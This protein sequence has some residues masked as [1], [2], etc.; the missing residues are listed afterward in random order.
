MDILKT[1][2][3]TETSPVVP[4]S[5]PIARGH[6][7]IIK[8]ARLEIEGKLILP[9]SARTA[10]NEGFIMAK[11]S[12]CKGDFPIGIRV[13]FNNMTNQVIIHDEEMYL[14]AHE[15]DVFGK[16]TSSENGDQLTPFNKTIFL[17]KGQE[18]IKFKGVFLPNTQKIV[19][20]G[21]IIGIGENVEKDLKVGQKIIH[22]L[23]ANQSFIFRTREVFMM[24]DIDVYAILPEGTYS[25]PSDLGR[26]RR[27]D[28]PLE[29]LKKI[30]KPDAF[31]GTKTHYTK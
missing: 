3:K 2:D 10:H 27:A 17:R 22:N 30:E 8:P 5:F 6:S 9:D 13:V 14:I 28:I 16:I 31:K 1:T 11:G 18:E 24:A 23:F 20:V 21:Y 29:D 26:E 25:T 12:E 15:A 4:K 19:N 7:V